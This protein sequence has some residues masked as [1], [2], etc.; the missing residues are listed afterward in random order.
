LVR[1]ARSTPQDDAPGWVITTSVL[2]HTCCFPDNTGT[3]RSGGNV[4]YKSIQLLS[5]SGSTGQAGAWLY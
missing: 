4:S 5:S 1:A 3:T 2:E